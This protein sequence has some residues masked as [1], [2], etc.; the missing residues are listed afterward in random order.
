VAG[1]CGIPTGAVAIS[2]NVAVVAPSAGG[3]LTAFTGSTGASLP[4]A[5]TINFQTNRTLANN[6][7]VRVGSD[8]IN[9]FDGGPTLH[10]VID[11]NGYFK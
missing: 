2:I 10:F 9:I 7:V 11:V 6:A 4:L 1:L 3:Y 8:S 5:S